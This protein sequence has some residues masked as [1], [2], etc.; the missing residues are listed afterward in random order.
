MSL[1]IAL[2]VET[3]SKNQIVHWPESYYSLNDVLTY[4]NEQFKYL[5]K[6]VN[7]EIGQ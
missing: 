4:G 5:E 7:K 1:K 6:P 3:L 2:S